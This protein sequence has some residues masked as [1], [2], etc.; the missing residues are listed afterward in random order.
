MDNKKIIYEL[1][2]KNIIKTGNFILKSGIKSNIYFDLRTL[3]A[4]P[5]ILNQVIK[6]MYQKISHLNFDLICGIAYTGIPM[7]T[8]ISLNNDIPML[9][10]RKEKKDYGTKKLIEGIYKSGQSC[11]M[12][13]DVITTGSS[14]IENINILNMDGIN[15]NDIIVFIDRRSD[16]NDIDEYNLHSVLNEYEIIKFLDN[17]IAEKILY[18]NY[19][20]NN[21]NPMAEKLNKLILEKETNLILSADILKKEEF[22]NLV[23]ITG[24]YICIVKTHIDMIEDFDTDLI[25]QLVNLSKKH[26]FMI[27]E[28]RKFA[29]IGNTVKHQ[30]ENG[31]YKI[32]EWADFITVHSIMGEG[33]IKAIKDVLYKNSLESERGI[34]L[35]ESVSSEGNLINNDYSNNTI[36]IAEGHIDVVSGFISQERKSLNS[37][38]FYAMPGVNIVDNGDK[39]GQ[40]YN[41]PENAILN[42]GADMIIVGRGIY[43][44]ENVEES[45]KMYRERGWDSYMYKNN[46]YDM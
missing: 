27:M 32:V 46:K 45:L 6:M 18:N 16:R 41:S 26:N 3:I 35:L 4:Y 19:F 12:L 31:I 7:A 37:N 14:L 17:N 2:K 30:Y 40:Q 43:M 36:E 42:C 10:I 29:D 34:F 33:T 44:A 11:L 9:I 20:G 23:S 39:F 38:F 24:P 22:L 13:D 8:K 1:F 5:D 15:V 28:D 21:Y 25:E